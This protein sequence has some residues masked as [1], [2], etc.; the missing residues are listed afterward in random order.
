MQADWKK[1]EG[2]VVNKMFPLRKF[3]GSTSHSAVFLTQSAHEQPKNLAIKF[4]SAGAK[5]D[6][7]A[8]LFHRASKLSHPNLLR[9][10]PGGPCKLGDMD[11]VFAVMEY[12]EQDL[13]RVLSNGPLTEKEARETLGTLLAAL[14]YIHSNG[15]AHSHIKPSNIMAVDDQLKLACD[16]VL[17]LGEARPDF[18][19]VDAYDAPE[20]GT[21]RVAGSSD[22]WS[23]GVT[24]VEMLTQ[25]TPT[26]LQESQADPIVPPT[27]PQPFLDIA[28]RCLR[29]DPSLRWTTAQTEACLKPAPVQVAAPAVTA[30]VAK[31]ASA[32]VAAPQVAG[33]A[34][35]AMESAAGAW[36][37]IR[38]HWVV[39]CKSYFFH[40]KQNLFYRHRIPLAVTDPYAPVPALDG[41]FKVR[42]DDC[43]KT[44]TYKRSEV[45]RYEQEIT[46]SFTPHPLFR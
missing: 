30:G 16:T 32:T 26:S 18:R 21:A 24:L 12:A 34:G 15:F 44:H 7:Q 40:M 42:C 23:L 2:Q 37:D 25:R 29:R 8:S 17:P 41:P 38:Y 33:S 39:L 46:K 5:A 20:A 13:G 35:K 43:G 6:W 4:I 27:L 3:L 11:L 36:Q 22:V 45:R 19:P 31:P 10:L 28:R 14:G 9:L 1:F